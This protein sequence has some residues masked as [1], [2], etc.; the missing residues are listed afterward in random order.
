MKRLYIKPNLDTSLF[1]SD[2]VLT[3]SQGNYEWKDD[4]DVGQN[5]IYD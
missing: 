4:D 1:G 3:V 5:D 2:S